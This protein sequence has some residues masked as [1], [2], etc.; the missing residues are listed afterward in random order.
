MPC[1]EE[2]KFVKNKFGYPSLLDAA[3]FRYNKNK[4]KK[5]KTTGSKVYWSC[6]Y[7]KN[8]KCKANVATAR[9]TIVSKTN[10]HNHLAGQTPL[11]YTPPA[12]TREGRALKKERIF[13]QQ[14]KQQLTG[15]GKPEDPIKATPVVVVEIAPSAIPVKR[16]PRK[17]VPTKEWN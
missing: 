10:R 14:Q 12:T 17:P 15:S 4:T 11:A 7:K 2:A 6:M 1:S 3:G 13:A 5:N 8:G 9:F 16:S